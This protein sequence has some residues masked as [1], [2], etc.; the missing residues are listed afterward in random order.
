M[1]VRE[2][3]FVENPNET[4]QLTNFISYG[5][6]HWDILLYLKPRER[7]GLY[8]G[9]FY[10]NGTKLDTSDSAFEDVVTDFVWNLKNV[11]TMIAYMAFIF[12]GTKDMERIY[13]IIEKRKEEKKFANIDPETGKPWI[14][15]SIPKTSNPN[16]INPSTGLPYYDVIDPSTGRPYGETIDPSTG[17][18]YWENTDHATGKPYGDAN[19]PA[20]GLPYVDPTTGKTIIPGVPYTDPVTGEVIIPGGKPSLPGISIPG[21]ISG[22]DGGNGGS[23]IRDPNKPG[24]DG[25][26]V[27]VGNNGGYQGGISSFHGN[28]TAYRK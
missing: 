24:G 9:H 17:K 3:F 23:V 21:G 26:S 12:C 27:T 18:P 16:T 14:V 19:N 20:T 28:V 11:D 4:F 13:P 2:D 10:E 15:G 25:D 22:G 8:D 5:T 6:I 1:F 7:V